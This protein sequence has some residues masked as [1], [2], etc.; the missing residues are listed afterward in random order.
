MPCRLVIS[1]RHFKDASSSEMQLTIHQ[2]TW[3][4]VP[5]DIETS[6]LLW[7]PQISR[8]SERFI[9]HLI[10]DKDTWDISLVAMTYYNLILRPSLFWNAYPEQGFG[11]VFQKQS[12]YRPG[13]ALRVPR[14]WSS[15]ISR[16]SAHESVK[17]V[18]PAH[19]PHLPPRKYSWY[20]FLLG[21]KST[22]R[23]LCGR[24]DYVN[25]NFQ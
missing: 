11:K 18:N 6:K 20:S 7:E 24:K 25:E 4:K 21:A 1:Y 5:Q 23:P 17:V 12:L 16:Q 13:Q 22:P 3:S 10:H 19:R 15:H 8:I 2:S 14:G 9:Y